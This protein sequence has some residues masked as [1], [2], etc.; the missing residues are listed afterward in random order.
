VQA[1]AGW[2]HP[3][4]VGVGGEQLGLLCVGAK[5]AADKQHQTGFAAGGG[6]H[7]VERER[8]VGAHRLA[9]AVGQRAAVA[10]AAGIGGPLEAGRVQGQ[11]GRGPR[12]HRYW[13]RPPPA[14]HANAGTSAHRHPHPRGAE[15]GTWE[16]HPDPVRRHPVAARAPP[17]RRPGQRQKSRLRQMPRI[18]RPVQ[19]HRWLEQPRIVIAHHLR[20]RHRR[21]IRRPLMT[22][23]RPQRL[24]KRKQHQQPR[25]QRRH[26]PQ[27]QQR[28]L[29]LLAAAH[30]SGAESTGHRPQPAA[31][32]VT[33]QDATVTRK[34]RSIPSSPTAGMPA[35]TPCPAAG[36]ASRS[37]A[38]GQRQE[39]PR[40]APSRWPP[41]PAT[42]SAARAR[43]GTRSLATAVLTRASCS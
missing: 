4:G 24:P 28:R 34:P 16:A 10:A 25:Q 38:P 27:Q 6:G 26:Q 35:P 8:H 9:G 19:Q 36:P 40:N 33:A 1:L 37:Q 7:P 18:G 5:A 14:R 30:T 43:R 13:R 15:T 11:L 29:P 39:R 22:P 3:F 17:G 12:P 21:Q 23:L 42:L 31:A 20:R 41:I 32:R 2:R